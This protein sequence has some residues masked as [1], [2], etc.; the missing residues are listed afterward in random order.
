MGE[1]PGMSQLDLCARWSDEETSAFRYYYLFSGL[2]GN[3]AKQFRSL[4]SIKPVIWG[5]FWAHIPKMWNFIGWPLTVKRYSVAKCCSNCIQNGYEPVGPFVNDEVKKKRAHFATSIYS[6]DFWAII[7]NNFV[8]GTG[9]ASFFSKR[10]V[11]FLN[12]CVFYY[13][14]ANSE[15][16]LLLTLGIVVEFFCFQ[17]EEIKLRFWRY[18]FCFYVFFYRSKKATTMPYC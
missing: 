4:S 15:M 9:I 11:S 14:S 12:I 2:L 5:H 10:L 16:I 18:W 13:T 8:F 6:L 3:N 17:I 1:K 7:P